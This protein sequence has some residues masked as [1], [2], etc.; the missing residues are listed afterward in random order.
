MKKLQEKVEFYRQ[1]GFFEKYKDNSNE[2]LTNLLI[3]NAKESWWGELNEDLSSAD[4]IILSLDTQKAWFID[5]YYRFGEKFE[6]QQEMYKFTLKKLEEISNEIFKAENVNIELKGFCSGRAER[7][8]MTFDYE[9]QSNEIIFCGDLDILIIDW[10]TRIN[11]L[12][13]KSNKKF[14][15]VR[16]S[17]SHLVLCIDNEKISKIEQNIKFE[18]FND[19]YYWLDIGD[20]YFEREEYENA[21]KFYQK[22][23]KEDKNQWYCYGQLSTSF[24]YLK[25]EEQEK[26]ILKTAINLLEKLENK[27]QTDEW[28]LNFFQSQLKKVI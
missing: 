5:D 6:N 10:I 17:S 1:L 13:K 19:Y 12:I 2:E 22:A 24:S 14:V 16:K 9:N 20:F 7:W 4:L 8:S 3:N 23:I 18:N 15:S 26:S 28:Y 27:E 21:I 25:D 11:H